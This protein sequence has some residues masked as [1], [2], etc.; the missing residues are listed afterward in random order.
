MTVGAKK[1]PVFECY[2][3]EGLLIVAAGADA[4]LAAVNAEFLAD[5]DNARDHLPD[6]L[7]DDDIAALAPIEHVIDG[8]VPA[9][10][11]SVLFGEPGVG[12]THALLG[13]T[14][15]VRR[16]TNWQGYATQHG[17]TLFYQGEGLRQLQDRIAAWDARY[18]LRKGRK[19]L[20]GAA[21][22]RV[23]DLTV[24]EGVA[25]VIRTVQ[26]YE[27]QHGV[28]VRLLVIDPLVEYMTGEEN[29]EGMELASRGLRALAK[30]LD[31]GVVVGHH[32]NASGDRERGAA[33][34]KM[35]AG[36][37]IRMEKLDEAGA[38]LG[39][40]AQ[41]QRNGERL[42][43]RLSMQ[44]SANSVVLTWTEAMLAEEY[45]AKKAGDRKRQSEDEKASLAAAK[46]DRALDL[47]LAAVAERPGLSKTK[48]LAATKAQGV[49]TDLLE[50]AL[51][52]LIAVGRIDVRGGARGAQQH[53]G[54]DA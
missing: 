45:S 50:A 12:K 37:H 13:M 19:M 9:G 51:D 18:P 35:R 8:W 14:R 24:P 25:A 39:V 53:Y 44:P 6:L 2:D 17:A 7:D 20:P 10:A 26:G 48:L 27:A 46:R 11:Y 28:K 32:T 15:A 41:K 36:A 21:T 49:G 52:R 29:G 23:V 33:F 3:N 38:E 40:V 4:V 5:M 34:L 16:G 1:K 30:L 47:L 22:D 42:A 54:V 43:L 31:I